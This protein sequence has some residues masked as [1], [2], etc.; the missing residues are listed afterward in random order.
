MPGEDALWQYTPPLHYLRFLPPDP[1]SVVVGIATLLTLAIDLWLILQR[2]AVRTAGRTPSNRSWW[3]LIGLS[4][5]L[6]I[7]LVVYTYRL[8]TTIIGTRALHYELTSRAHLIA[9]DNRTLTCVVDSSGGAIIHSLMTIRTAG[10]EPLERFELLHRLPDHPDRTAQSR[11]RPLRVSVP[12]DGHTV[13]FSR[14]PSGNPT[15]TIVEINPPLGPEKSIDLKQ[16]IPMEVPDSSIAMTEDESRG[17]KANHDPI[18]YFSF[19]VRYPCNRLKLLVRFP[20]GFVP[21]EPSYDVWYGNARV[22][23]ENEW[24]YIRGHYNQAFHV[25]RDPESD[26][27]EL[28]LV[29]DY[30]LLATN[31]A[32]T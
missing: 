20:P 26:A 32:V 22:R 23:H 11:I 8:H 7:C 14:D 1:F 31:Y 21:R 24:R 6:L 4:A 29:E 19:E 28:C 13:S 3:A 17:R 18:E 30:P 16:S 9:L 10:S 25:E 12:A 27:W 15:V 2:R 5:F